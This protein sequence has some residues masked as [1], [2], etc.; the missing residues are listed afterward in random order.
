MSEA[1]SLDTL[2]WDDYSPFVKQGYGSRYDWYR[3]SYILLRTNWAK[4][5]KSFDTELGSK[6]QWTKRLNQTILK[7]KRRSAM[8]WLNMRAW[9][10]IHNQE[11]KLESGAKNCALFQKILPC[12]GKFHGSKSSVLEVQAL[13]LAKF[14]AG[15]PPRAMNFICWNFRGLGNPAT[16][17]CKMIGCLAVDSKGRRGGLAL[18]WKDDVEKEEAAR[19][20]WERVRTLSHDF[21]V[22]NMVNKQIIPAELY[23][24]EEGVKLARSVNIEYA[25]FEIYCASIVNRIEKCKEDITINGHRT[26]EIHKTME[27]FPKV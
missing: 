3:Y 22:H 11:L 27:L 16:N 21:R 23:A 18:M 6:I 1:D 19:I 14:F 17:I 24:L 8:P 20:V 12:R 9:K 5:L 10:L 26:K 4:Y 15:T 25:I 7:G 13:L 2:S